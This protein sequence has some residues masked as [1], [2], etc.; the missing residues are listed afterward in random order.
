MIAKID[1]GGI[2]GRAGADH[3]HSSSITT[4]DRGRYRVFAR[5]FDDYPRVPA[6]AEN[7]PDLLAESTGLASPVLLP[8]LISPMR[9]LP[10]MCKLAPIDVSGGA[11]PLAVFSLLW[12]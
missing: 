12:I 2:P 8:L 11:E 9:R 1:H 3:H 10:P 5:V 7:I 4:E 6:F